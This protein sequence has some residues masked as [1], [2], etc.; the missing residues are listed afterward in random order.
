V[1]GFEFLKPEHPL[2]DQGPRWV[3][4]HLE[5]EAFNLSDGHRT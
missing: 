3:G 2:T 1:T 5:K 4:L